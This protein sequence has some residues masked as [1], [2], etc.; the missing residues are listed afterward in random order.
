MLSRSHWPYAVLGLQHR[1]ALLRPGRAAESS[2]SLAVAG[3][4]QDR[5]CSLPPR[6]FADVPPR[7]RRLLA[8]LAMMGCTIG[9]LA[10]SLA[11]SLVAVRQRLC[12]LRARGFGRAVTLWNPER[13]GLPVCLL[14]HVGL[15]HVVPNGL[16]RFERWCLQ[17]RWVTRADLVAG[18]FDY[19]LWSWHADLQRSEAWSNALAAREEVRLVVSRPVRL[20]S[21]HTLPGAPI[22][23]GV[24]G[25][26]PGA[27]ASGKPP[28]RRAGV[29][30]VG[31]SNPDFISGVPSSPTTNV[32]R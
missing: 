29:I 12:V 14:T 7:D 28:E 13:I 26:P 19:Q 15:H 5:R 17:D 20:L 3:P 31:P 10:G 1:R 4:S 21:G 30:A 32:I 9:N 25:C 27:V 22:F 11:W 23:T 16:V 24:E 18:R 2:P 6:N 8:A